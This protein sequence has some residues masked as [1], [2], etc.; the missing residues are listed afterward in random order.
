MDL[1]DPAA[2]FLAGND[3][4]VLGNPELG[5]GLTNFSLNAGTTYFLVVNG[6]FPTDAGAFTATISG[7]GPIQVVPEPS[8]RALLLLSALGLAWIGFRKTPLNRA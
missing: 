8:T 4:R 6:F 5:S 2:S 7:N 1:S 3:D